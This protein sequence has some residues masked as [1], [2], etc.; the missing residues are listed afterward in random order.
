MNKNSKKITLIRHGRPQAYEDNALFSFVAG[1]EIEHIVKAYNTCELSPINEVPSILGEIISDGDLFISSE[2][3]R[4]KDSFH[5]VGIKKFESNG[6]LNEADF[7]YGIGKN[8][9]MPL[10]LWLIVLRLFWRFGLST[11]SESFKDFKK[12]VK[13]GVDHIENKAISSTHC[14]IMAHGFTNQIIKNELLSRKW[15]LISNTG[16]YGYW[17]TMSFKKRLSQD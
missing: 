17:S 1:S 4:T 15:E 2:L 12:R 6:F 9:K 5:K 11:N 8:I 14:I 16:G 10:V 7:P 3:K 13:N